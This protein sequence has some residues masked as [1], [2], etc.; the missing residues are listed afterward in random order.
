MKAADCSCR[1]S[2]SSMRELRRDSTT[3]RFSSPGTPKT[4]STPSLSR[5]ETKRSDPFVILVILPLASSAR[6]TEPE[7]VVCVFHE[8]TQVAPGFVLALRYRY[9]LL[10][11]HEPILQDP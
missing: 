10:D 3:S 5:A 11:G 4:R 2:T 7:A 1:V 6:A 9:G 8:G